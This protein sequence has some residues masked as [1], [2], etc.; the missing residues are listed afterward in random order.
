MLGALCG[1]HVP[2][3]AGTP[4]HPA[5]P[6]QSPPPWTA[7]LGA[8]RGHPHPRNLWCRLEWEPCTEH[9]AR[10]RQSLAARQQQA[11]QKPP[12]QQCSSPAASSAGTGAI[13]LVRAAAA[14]P[15]VHRP[16][17]Q[18]TPRF[19][20]SHQRLTE[21]AAAGHQQL[22]QSQVGDAQWRPAVSAVRLQQPA[23]A[24]ALATQEAASQAV[25][26]GQSRKLTQALTQAWLGQFKTALAARAVPVVAAMTALKA[27]RRE[28]GDGP[29]V[30][31]PMDAVVEL[32][33]RAAGL[34]LPP[35]QQRPI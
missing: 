8:V 9:A 3:N 12:P 6:T 21:S 23:P 24:V 20:H 22:Q 10:I 19:C 35:P 32:C 7:G 18:V 25:A 34:P 28:H 11:S 2:G 14:G 17:S 4:A 30:Q 26:P 1:M 33:V 27:V 13:M 15:S 31:M 29:L 5:P 16:E